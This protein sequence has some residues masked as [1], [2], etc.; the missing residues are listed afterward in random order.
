MKRRILVV[1]LAVA[2]CLSALTGC[3]GKK[4]D[5]APANKSQQTQKDSGGDAADKARYDV[6][7]TIKV[8]IDKGRQP[9]I[10][11]VIEK[12]KELYKNIKVDVVRFEAG[13]GTAEYLTAQASA[14]D[15]PDVIFDDAGQLTYYISQGWV[16]PLD[17]FVAN[18]ADLNY[19]PKSILDTYTYGG[20]L[21][22]V[23]LAAHFNTI[24]LNVD[25]LDELNLD[26]PELDWTPQDYAELLKK[27][28]NNKYSGTEILWGM[29]E[30]F[31][32]AM[33][34]NYNLYAYDFATRTYYLS[35]TWVKGV[36][37]MREM[38][39]YPGLEAWTLRNSS[40]DGGTT[41]YVKKFGQGNT[42]DLHMAFKMGKILSDPRGTWDVPWLRELKYE[43]ELWPFPQGEKGHL[44]MHVDHSFMIS[45]C[46]DPQAAF[47]FIRYLSYSPEGNIARLDMYEDGNRD[48]ETNK[49]LFFIP[50]TNH[51]DV[52]AKFK[53]LPNVTEGIAYMYDSVKTSYRSD[54]SKVIP[55]YDQVN[56]EYL[57]PRG[58]EV[59][60]GIADATA[61]AAE[62]Q[63]VASKAQ[64]GYWNE[65]DAKL[66]TVQEEFD[67][68]HK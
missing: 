44:P 13:G 56:S 32:G 15:M 11:P 33:S 43:W 46:K 42:D 22:A 8:V 35:D 19:V 52:S 38:R 50:T 63:D 5:P 29:D 17:K 40:A 26:H 51:P 34:K 30:Y 47:E 36:N 4:K 39:A 53:A 7:G 55:N 3:E 58:N 60:D 68:K 31:A 49:N 27:A 6:S 9:G 37:L 1:F 23:P 62:L 41:D 66:K 65:F 48:E 21:Y 18:D 20:K 64:Q 28:T 16:Y 14:N 12:F 67:S 24:F 61:V 2:M 57:S 59:R 25:L 45:S 54:L 10:E